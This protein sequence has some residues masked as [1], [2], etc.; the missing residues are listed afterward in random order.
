MLEFSIGIAARVAAFFAE[1]VFDRFCG[2]IGRKAVRCLSLGRVQIDPDDG[3][4]SVLASA[5]GLLVLAGGIS[6]VAAAL[7]ALPF[8][9]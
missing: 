8:H 9:D 2:V 1:Y 4:E 7:F 6:L 5:I 3:S